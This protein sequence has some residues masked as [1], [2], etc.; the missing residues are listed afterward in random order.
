MTLFW[1]TRG[2]RARVRRT[3]DITSDDGQGFWF[4]EFRVDECRVNEFR[5]DRFRFNSFP[6]DD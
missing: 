5:F 2:P 3:N 4:D 1:V 6:F